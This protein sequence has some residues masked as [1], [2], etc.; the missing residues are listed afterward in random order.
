MLKDEK[1]SSLVIRVWRYLSHHRQKQFYLLL[2]LTLIS[3]FSEFISLGLIIPFLGVIVSPETAYSQPFVAE[4]SAIVGIKTESQLILTLTMMFIVMIIISSLIRML[5]LWAKNR[6]AYS[7]GT[8]LSSQIYRK[9]LYQ[10]YNVH[11]MRNS[12]ELISSITSKLSAIIG[13]FSHILTLITSVV[14]I[15]FVSLALMIIDS[16]VAVTAL[17]SFGVMYYIISLVTKNRLRNNSK[18]FAEGSTN[19][20]IVLQEGLG[21]I[22]DVILDNTQEVYCDIHKK[23]DYKMRRAMG[24]NNFIA[25]SPR[26]L[27]EAIGM[28][29]LVALS[30]VLSQTSDG[31]MTAIPLLGALALGAQRLLPAFQQ[32]YGAWAAMLGSYSSLK[33]I[34]YLLDQKI[35]KEHLVSIDEEIIFNSTLKLNNI[36]FK[37]QE[38]SKWTLN[39]LSLTIK[40]GDKVGFVGSTGCG[41]STTIDM[42]MGLLT[43]ARGELLVDDE[44]ISPQ[45]YREWQKKI[46]HVPQAIYLSDKTIAENIAFGV[47]INKIDYK[48]MHSATKQAKID[49]YIDNLPNGYKTIV[50]ERGVRLS[51]GQRQRIGIARALYK[52]ASIVI[53]D[54][55][56]SALDNLTEKMILDSI[57]LIESDIT[58]IVIAHRLTTVEHCDVIFEIDQGHIKNQ[59][60]YQEL[61]KNSATFRSM[62]SKQT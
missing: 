55:A 36:C 44:L 10:P 47:E 26:V 49:D 9:T 32:G 4:L 35:L 50:G 25:A 13:V 52:R 24:D 39:E 6:L 3:G 62:A 15:L 17:L 41:K 61:L 30:Y 12:S 53:F 56:T 46:A 28:L 40:K 29:L 18:L 48:R 43:P 11:L 23:S 42:L 59:G 8:D 37:Y 57:D 51:G 33:D 60:T 7:S 27:M 34:L 45:N 19:L 31:I 20:V 38:E 54:E 14:M 58:I 2:V 5:L 21:G 22:R 1:L 16:I